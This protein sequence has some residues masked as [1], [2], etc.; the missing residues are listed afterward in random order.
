MVFVASSYEYHVSIATRQERTSTIRL[1]SGNSLMIIGSLFDSPG[2][3]GM[4]RLSS[5]P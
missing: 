1:S 5:T 2:R 4:N 3:T